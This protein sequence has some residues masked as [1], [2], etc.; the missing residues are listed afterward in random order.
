M[1]GTRHRNW[2]LLTVLVSSAFAGHLLAG[3]GTVLNRAKQLQRDQSLIQAIVDGG[4]KLATEDDPLKRAEE[5]NRMAD[6]LAGEAKLAFL[7]KDSERAVDLSDH[8][9]QMLVQGVASNLSMA[10]S[11]MGPNSPREKDMARV[12]A[13]AFNAAKKIEDEINRHP[14][15]APA[16]MQ[17]TL[18]NIDKGK[19]EVQKAMAGKGKAK[20]KGKKARDV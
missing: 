9:Q 15:F 10:K 13:A 18:K 11:A 5:C 16:K 3:P 8:M 14:A 2:L 4:V 1:I 6:I 20:A 19:I 12:G 17:S 7:A